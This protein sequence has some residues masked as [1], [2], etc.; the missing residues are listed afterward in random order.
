MTWSEV[1]FDEKLDHSGRTNESKGT[2]P[3]PLSDRAVEILRSGR[4]TRAIGV[5]FAAR[6]TNW[7]V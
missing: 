5:P 2:P 3:V 7:A 6:K 1:N 4:S